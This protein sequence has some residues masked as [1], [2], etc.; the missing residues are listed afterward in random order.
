MIQPFAEVCQTFLLELFNELN[1]SD[2]LIKVLKDEKKLKK[3]EKTPL[4]RQNMS[5]VKKRIMLKFD[6]ETQTQMRIPVESSIEESGSSLLTKRM[7]S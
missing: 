7:H 6:K 5:A 2:R 4:K 1:F 3:K